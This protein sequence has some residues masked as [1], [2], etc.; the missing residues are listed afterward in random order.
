M[1]MEP[2]IQKKLLEIFRTDLGDQ[3]QIITDSLLA[4]ESRP[5]AE[6]R[7]E[8]LE[9]M[10]RAAHNL[11]GAARRIGVTTI[12]EITHHLETL[13][14]ELKN[15]NLQPPATA[16]DLSLKTLDRLRECMEAYDT[17]D[18]LPFDM[19]DLIENLQSIAKEIAGSNAP[20]D[21]SAARPAAPAKKSTAARKVKSQIKSPTG[22]SGGEAPIPEPTPKPTPEPEPEPEPTPAPTAMPEPKATAV[23]AASPAPVSSAAKKPV[24][25]DSI[26]VSIDRLETISALLE[27]MQVARIELDDHW[28]APFEWSRVN[29]SA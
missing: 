29:V 21:Q 9:P 11:K 26:R 28:S 2:E 27:E 17:G 14:A 15:Q 18:D 24:G 8:V 5:D 10:M 20:T 6:A 19:A 13:F 23:T 25:Q 16:I 3:L 1:A 12:G 4:L 7:Q 22:A